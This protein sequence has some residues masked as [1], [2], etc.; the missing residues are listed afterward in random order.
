MITAKMMD[1]ETVAACCCYY[2]GESASLANEQALNAK[3][4]KHEAKIL[5]A[6]RCITMEFHCVVS[7]SYYLKLCVGCRV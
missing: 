3:E 7:S 6:L 1:I 5:A 4:K 2:G